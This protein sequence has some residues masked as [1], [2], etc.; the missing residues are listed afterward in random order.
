MI[1]LGIDAS[2]RGTG[3]AVIEQKGSQVRARHWEGGKLPAS[4][5]H[6]DCLR[7][8]SERGDALLAA[9]RPDA[10]AVE[11]G[12][13]FKTAKVAMVLAE[14]RGLTIAS[15]ALAGVP[16]FEYSPRKA[17]QN[18]TGWGAAP[19]E[20]VARMVKTILGLDETPPNDA[21]D[22]LALALCHAQTNQGLIKNKPI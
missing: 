11:G 15:S 2:L 21:T 10:A 9:H 5:P 19:K 18:I 16:V 20:Q 6:S 22:A 12:F 17:K 8:I 14:V 3:L 13:F 4:D 1:V 7:A